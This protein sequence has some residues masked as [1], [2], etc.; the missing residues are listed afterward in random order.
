[1]LFVDYDQDLIGQSVRAAYA[2]LQSEGFP[3]LVD[4]VPSESISLNAS[5]QDV[6]QT[7]CWA[8]PYVSAGATGRLGAALVGGSAAASYYRSDVLTYICNEAQYLATVDSAI[9]DNLRGLSFATQAAYTDKNGTGAIQQLDS[10]DAAAESVLSN[11][12]RLTS[13][14]IQPTHRAQERSTTCQ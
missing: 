1:V 14:N 13:I 2:I 7:R 6:C 8:A 4:S 5:R 3:T 11:P 12:W 9:M 10:S